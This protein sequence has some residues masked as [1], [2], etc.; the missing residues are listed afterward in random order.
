MAEQYQLI[1]TGIL[2]DWT[3]E[4]AAQTLS[5]MT[6]SPPEKTLALLKKT[7]AKFGKPLP[8]DKAEKYQGYLTKS[9]LQSSLMKLEDSASTLVIDDPAPVAM[10]M[11]AAPVQAAAM[12]AV[13][14]LSL[15][16]TGKEESVHKAE[17]S[18]CPNCSA[19]R[20]HGSEE[21]PSCG[22]VFAKYQAV[23]TDGV[24][25]F[26]AV[27]EDNYEDDEVIELEPEE[28]T[29][30]LKNTYGLLGATLVFSAITCFV[31]MTMGIDL[32]FWVF[33]IGALVLLGVTHVT[34]NSAMGLVSVFA[35]TGWMGLGIGPIIDL[36][37]G[38]ANGA[39]LIGTAGLG[40]ATIFFGLSA[41]VLMTKK[42]F[43]FMGGLL[44]S[45]LIVVIVGGIAAYFFQLTGLALAMSCI[46][47]FV[48]S[49]YILYDTSKII[50]RGETNYI[51]ATV[52][53]YLD[54]LNLFLS[55]LRVLSYFSG[56]E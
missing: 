16:P 13:G 5:S 24:M 27:G 56:E 36:Y 33:L 32:G 17:K 21:C 20:Q 47:I 25:K 34:K 29:K 37:L 2:P 49:G 53:L 35:F 43:S 15:V 22:I 40:T 19:D 48:F 6:K 38:L 55:L 45:G 54:I 23:S 41:Y 18:V 31:G 10:A 30:M 52:E 4:K 26:D 9:G 11:A 50:H 12:S 39:Q 1:I 8:K 44:F 46:S 51:I 42:D 3:L 28:V 14:G 7:P